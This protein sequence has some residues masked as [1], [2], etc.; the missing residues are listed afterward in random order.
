MAQFEAKTFN[1]SD[2]NYGQRYQNGDIVDANAINAPI[3]AALLIQSLATSDIDLSDADTNGVASVTIVQQNG[4]F[5][6]K[7]SH[8]KGN[9]PVKGTDYFTEADKQEIV[10]K[11][12]AKFTRAEGSL[13]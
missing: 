7:F 13:F 12:V 9:T 2:I 1:P 4:Q 10:D 5:K 6:F 11:V 8:I 3:E